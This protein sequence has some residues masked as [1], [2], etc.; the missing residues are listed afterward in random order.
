VGL[1]RRR[2]DLAFS[3]WGGR[4]TFFGAAI[5]GHEAVLEWLQANYP[6]QGEA[7]AMDVE[8]ASR[9]LDAVEWLQTIERRAAQR[10]PCM[11]RLHPVIWTWSN[12]CM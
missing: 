4:D 2:T 6:T 9:Y 7:D 1:K 11:R 10:P 5:G 8:A 3:L 12:G